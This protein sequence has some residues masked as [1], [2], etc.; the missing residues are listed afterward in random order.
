MQFP[1]VSPKIHPAQTMARAVTA[2]PAHLSAT[3]T[4]LLQ[5]AQPGHTKAKPLLAVFAP[6]RENKKY[7]DIM[8]SIT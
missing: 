6:L 5:A 3:L 8:Q 1:G 2:G 4:R 7:L